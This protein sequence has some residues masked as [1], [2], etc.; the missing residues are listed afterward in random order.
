MNVLVT[1][2]HLMKP[3]CRFPLLS[4][5]ELKMYKQLCIP[6]AAHSESFRMWIDSCILTVACDTTVQGSVVVVGH[7][8][9]VAICAE[10][11]C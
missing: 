1:D 11:L 2:L 8:K 3:C 4:A 9:R 5:F 10:N 6:A 7:A